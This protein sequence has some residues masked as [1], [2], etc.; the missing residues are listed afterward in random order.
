MRW[1]FE[2]DGDTFI[3]SLSTMHYLDLALATA[4]HVVVVYDPADPRVNTLYL[5]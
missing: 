1:S 4:K 3:G 5:G 2:A